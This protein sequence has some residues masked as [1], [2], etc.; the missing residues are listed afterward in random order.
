MKTKEWKQFRNLKYE[1]S[2]DGEIRNKKTGRILSQRISHQGY[3]Q[4]D[5]QIDKKNITFRAH[6]IV[7]EAFLGPGEDGFH[8]DHINRIRYD[9]R[10]E[11]L[12]WVTPKENYENRVFVKISLILISEIIDLYKKG[13][14][15]EEI[16]LNIN[17]L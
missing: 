17:K 5:I 12:R 3:K 13:K 10:I 11:N 15:F 16:H 6:R 9:N 1:A 14:T 2:S 8:V 7:A 4:V